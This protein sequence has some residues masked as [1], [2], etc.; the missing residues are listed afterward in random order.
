MG[1]DVEGWVGLIS[2]DRFGS[3]RCWSSSSSVMITIEE[4]LKVLKWGFLSLNRNWN[5]VGLNFD[6]RSRTEK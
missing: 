4:S 6:L 1:F 3:C 5:W 2:D